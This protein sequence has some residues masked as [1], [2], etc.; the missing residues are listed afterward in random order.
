MSF[1]VNKKNAEK[2][3]YSVSIQNIYL[4]GLDN[5]EVKKLA[6]SIAQKCSANMVEIKE[7]GASETINK[8]L[9]K[10]MFKNQTPKLVVYGCVKTSD[11]IQSISD[12]YFDVITYCF[13]Y[14]QPSKCEKPFRVEQDKIY[15]EYL[16]KFDN[17]I[18]TILYE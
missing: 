9:N 10:P 3:L 8:Y 18:L 1:V 6:K 13:L 15:K 11:V 2:L 14:K 4:N 7:E 12:E 5:D 16:E 17:Q